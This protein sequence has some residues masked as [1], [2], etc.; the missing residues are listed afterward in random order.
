[1]NFSSF[2][3]KRLF[4]SAIKGFSFGGASTPGKGSS[5]CN[6]KTSLF[7]STKSLK[8]PVAQ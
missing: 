6:V 7:D 3:S 8:P 5:C 4:G 2:S 1:M